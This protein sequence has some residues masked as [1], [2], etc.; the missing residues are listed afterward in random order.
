MTFALRYAVRS[1]VGLLRE[2]NEDSAYAS[3]RLLA[4]ADGMGGHAAGEVASAVAIAAVAELDLPA[5]GGDPLDTLKKAVATA[6][7]TLRQMAAADPAVE[8]LG[9]TLTAMLWSE[10]GYA[11]C[12]I[13]DSRAYLLRDGDLHRITHDHSLV[14]SLVDEGRISEQEAAS[15][16]QRSLILRALDA[17]GEAEPDLSMRD[18]AAGDRYLLCSDGLS[19]VVGDAEIRRTLSTVPD[20]DAAATALIDL[21]NA[22]GGP[23]NITVVVADVAD[24]GEAPRAGAG[25]SAVFAGAASY[26]TIGPT[27]GPDDVIAFDRTDTPRAAGRPLARTGPRGPGGAAALDAYP[28]AGDG[29]AAT[30]TAIWTATEPNAGEPNA[31]EPN[32]DGPRSARELPGDEPEVDDDLERGAEL[33]PAA[34]RGA[35]RQHGR[36]RWP[37]VTTALLILV[38]AIVGGGYAAWAYTQQQYY[39]GLDGNQVAIFRGIDQQVAGVRLFSLYQKTGIAAQTVPNAERDAIHDTLSPTSL[40][41]ARRVVGRLR[42]QQQQCESAYH[43]QQRWLSAQAQRTGTGSPKGPRSAAQAAPTPAEPT[44][45][46]Y[47][48]PASAFGITDSAGSA[49]AGAAQGASS[50]NAPAP[51]ASPGAALAPSPRS[52]R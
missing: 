14:Q 3:D 17:R 6:S 8:G 27:T 13:G 16:P 50:Q 20:I 12:H 19:D 31:D 39:I 25:G 28:A 35:R 52:S 48:P 7:R 4:V 38:A 37:L 33:R 43:A 9:T 47:C 46:D 51:S 15:H 36:R 18:A 2:G 41:D 24:A 32:A 11:L 30:T 1:D 49:R 45:P 10:H 34:D 22:G 40:P 42:Q 26:G 21:A 29:A 23:D 5:P 44:A